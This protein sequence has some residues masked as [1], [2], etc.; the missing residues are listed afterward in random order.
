MDITALKI[1]GF[2]TFL[3]PVDLVL[4]PGL[5]GIV[6]PNGCGKS[7]LVEAL[8]WVMGE[9]ASKNMRASNMSEVI[10]SGSRKRPPR[11]HAHVSV[12]LDNS[13][14]RAP[15]AFNQAD[16]LQISRH[17]VRDEGS[18]YQINGQ[19]VRARDITLLFAD[20][21]SGSRSPSMI[22]Q[23]R[24]GQIV[25][26]KPSER[27]IIL[28]EAAGIAGLQARR[29]EA[30]LRLKAAEENIERLGD[31]LDELGKQ[32]DQLKR[33]AQQAER[34]K[35]LSQ[36]I[37]WLESYRLAKGW[38][39]QDGI[40][41]R[42]ASDYDIIRKTLDTALGHQSS[43]ARHQAV[44]SSQVAKKREQVEELK[45]KRIELSRQK[46][47][48][49]MEHRQTSKTLENLDQQL[50]AIQ[51][52][53]GYEQERLKEAETHLADLTGRLKTMEQEGQDEGEAL[54]LQLEQ[55]IADLQAELMD[56]RSRQQTL[57]AGK[58]EYEARLKAEADQRATLLTENDKLA[59]DLNALE[60]KK[61]QLESAIETSF[62][63]DSSKSD[64][65]ALQQAFQECQAL[66]DS[67]DGL[68]LEARSH[69]DLAHQ[70]YSECK[71]QQASLSGEMKALR[72]RQASLEQNRK[73]GG[74]PVLHQLTIQKGAEKAVARALGEALQ[75]GFD[76]TG[77]LFWAKGETPDALPFDKAIQDVSSPLSAHVQGP[78]IVVRAL[79]HFALLKE[80][81]SAEDYCNRLKPGQALV[82]EQGDLWRSDGLVI[83]HHHPDS[84]SDILHIIRQIREIEKELTRGDEQLH[85]ADALKKRAEA[86]WNT[87]KAEEARLRQELDNRKIALR[88]A[89]DTFS[90]AEQQQKGLKAELERLEKDHRHLV[91]RQE[92]LAMRLASVEQ[93]EKNEPVSDQ[94]LHDIACAIASAEKQLDHK[95]AELSD[96]KARKAR[97]E[98]MHHSLERDHSSW[99]TRLTTSSKRLE[100]LSERQ[101]ALTEQQERLA[102]EPDNYV[103]TSRQ[104]TAQIA[105][106]DETLQQ[107]ERDL[108][109]REEALSET[110]RDNRKIIQVISE[111]KQMQAR[112]EERLQQARA[113]QRAQA[114]Q[115]LELYDKA[116]EDILAEPVPGHF[117]GLSLA[118]LEKR[119]EELKSRREKLGAINLLAGEE[120][121]RVDERYCDLNQ[122]K[123]DV[124]AAI[125]ELNKAIQHLN[126]EGR[127][128][129]LDA[130]QAVNE[131]FKTLFQTLFGGGEA[132]LM[133]VDDDDPLQAGLDIMARPPGKK[134]QNLS[135]LSGGEQALTA[136]A[137]IFA[138]FCTN[139][140]PLCVLD[141]VDAPL[142]DAN[143]ERFC[144][145][146]DR[147]IAQTRT[148]FLI[149]T[150]NPITMSRMHR[151]YGVT[152]AERGVSQLLSV[153]L[154]TGVRL[155]EAV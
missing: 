138:V 29:H 26:A 4:E 130:F 56:R 107:I 44:L 109:Q 25:T 120:Y 19:D 38:I 22:G 85:Q 73:E 1:S 100:E 37:R 88:K 105:S 94:T 149:I 69:H 67:H 80:G 2:K 113:H 141:E 46:D 119:A 23:G 123:E 92:E 41:R 129:T 104:L 30:S 40:C 76:K 31:I 11:S 42:L 114:A 66:L 27:R 106:L 134:P 81:A 33:Q 71:A 78:E 50:Q 77:S 143:V 7:N 147:M 112:L 98:A 96:L 122:E 59:E 135:L 87:V 15:P 86:N 142:D 136:I 5:T 127:R 51:Q 151:L 97:Q 60:H 17:I 137:L 12:T 91:S 24:I 101:K 10:F 20:L 75:A 63:H 21:A 9:N 83:C 115:C 84:Q 154:E 99:Q 146:L 110:D 132:E 62:H 57:L 61:Q 43:L 48:V 93:N 111:Q 35:A 65:E 34:Y 117:A 148:R 140:S 90:K 72:A 144:D 95:R 3:D 145:L 125:E 79:S 6:G 121:E 14:R 116:P 118:E 32:R 16:I 128:K 68:L 53:Q 74:D 36:D 152:M 150:H 124:A 70:N 18:R 131:T 28:E 102:Q 89:E 155:R 49:E 126:R 133:L 82:S 45:E 153:D 8:R 139:P 64:L 55:Q 58:A 47:R 54:R 13:S 52:D 108:V 39:E 103:Q